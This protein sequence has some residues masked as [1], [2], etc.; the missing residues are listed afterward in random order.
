M[1]VCREDCCF[2]LTNVACHCKFFCLHAN[3]QIESD[4]F[5]GLCRAK[6]A[7]VFFLTWVS[8]VVEKFIFVLKA[9]SCTRYVCGCLLVEGQSF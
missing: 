2:L 7:L 1:T 6:H 5:L 8:A 3:P 4:A 9:L